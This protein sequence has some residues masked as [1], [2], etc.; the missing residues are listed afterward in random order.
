MKR[1]GNA[2]SPHENLVYCV[3]NALR[4]FSTQYTKSGKR[5]GREQ[6]IVMD[7]KQTLWN[8]KSHAA[9]GT[10]TVNGGGIRICAQN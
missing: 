8:Y 6:A 9:S 7:I 10:T 1:L 5:H 3:E 2:A 4:A